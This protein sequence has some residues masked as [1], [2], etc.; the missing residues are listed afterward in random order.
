MSQPAYR[1]EAEGRTEVMH[2]CQLP[3]HLAQRSLPCRRG[4]PEGG[5][6]LRDLSPAPR[7]TGG[8]ER[9]CRLPHRGQKARG[10]DAAAAAV[11]HHEGAAADSAGWWSPDD[12]EGQG[13]RPAGDDPAPGISARPPSSAT[14]SP[15]DAIADSPASPVTRPPPASYLT[16]TPPR[17]CQICH[18]QR[19]PGATAPPVINRAELASAAVRS[20]WKSAVPKHPRTPA[21]GVLRAMQTHAKVQCTQCHTDAGESCAPKPKVSTCTSRQR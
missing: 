14:P 8:C 21:S 17:G 15:I 20:R 19:P 4:P 9:L 3:R 10:T 2:R 6:A 13:R 12:R 5:P 18:H 1:R 7:R 16:F 11:R